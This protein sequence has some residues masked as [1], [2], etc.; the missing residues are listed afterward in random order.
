MRFRQLCG[1]GGGGFLA[2]IQQGGFF[3]LDPENKVT[4]NGLIPNLVLIMVRMIIVNMQSYWLFYFRDLT[5]QKFPFQNGTKSHRDSIFT[6][7][8]RA[9]LEK[10]HFLCL[11]TSFLAQ[12]YTPSGFE[13]K[14]KN[15]RFNFSRGFISKT[16]AAW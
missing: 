12:I 7:C 6:P 4:I 9:K 15:R 8:N 2:Q 10:N 5:S 3:G 1:G 14:Q 11:K 16:T 13:A